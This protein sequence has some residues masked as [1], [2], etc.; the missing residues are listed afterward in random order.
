MVMNWYSSAVK[1]WS[2]VA[3][4]HVRLLT[5]VCKV[6]SEPNPKNTYARTRNDATELTFST[7]QWWKN[8]YTFV[9]KNSTWAGETA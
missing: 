8:S 5:T 1:E 7:D 2:F 4:A 3:K 6:K 9:S